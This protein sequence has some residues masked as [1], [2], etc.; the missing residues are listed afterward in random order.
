[1]TVYPDYPT[2][3]LGAEEHCTEMFGSEELR[4][5]ELRQL[6]RAVI[7]GRYEW[8]HR[9]VALRFLGLTLGT[10]TKLIGTFHTDDGP[11]V[12]TRSGGEPVGAITRRTYEPYSPARP[13]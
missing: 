6:I 4:L 12:F 13:R 10:Y 5:R 11:W 1:M 3:C 8:E 7:A 2:L 9:Q